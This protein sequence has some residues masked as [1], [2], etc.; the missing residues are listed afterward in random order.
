[1]TTALLPRTTLNCVN[2]CKFCKPARQPL[3]DDE[4]ARY[5]LV[6]KELDERRLCASLPPG[7]IVLIVADSLHAMSKRLRKGDPERDGLRRAGRA[8]IVVPLAAAVSFWAV[9]GSQ[10]PLFTIVGALWLMVLVDFP[11]DRRGRA[12]AHLGVGCNGAVLITVGT[13]AAPIPWVAV[14]LMFVLGVAVT[15]AG[16]L[17]ETIAVGQRVTLLAYSDRARR[18]AL[19]GLGNSTSRLHAG[20][21]VRASAAPPERSA[22]SRRKGV[23]CAGRPAGGRGIGVA[24][25]ASDECAAGQLL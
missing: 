13:L 22:Q 21:V 10:A 9:G 17:S 14:T 12:L 2:F 7:R 20:G 11:G 24:G 18:R 5:L 3:G 1:V 23:R 25:V 15:L 4:S 19:T 6:D 8:A 16:V